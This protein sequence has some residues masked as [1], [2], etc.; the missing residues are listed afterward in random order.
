MVFIP[1]YRRRVI[2]KILREDV[3]E[4]I[5]KLCQEMKAQ[6]I[7]AAACPDHIYLLASISPYMRIAQF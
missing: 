5:K 7:E 3:T 6:S 4:I 1:K 2:C